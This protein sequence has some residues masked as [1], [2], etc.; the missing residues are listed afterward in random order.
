M[1]LLRWSDKYSVNVPEMDK[2]HQTLFNMLNELHDAMLSGKAKTVLDKTLS[3][4][5][6]YTQRHFAI[7]ERLMQENNYAEYEDHKAVHEQLKTRVRQ[8]VERYHAG[9]RSVTIELMSFLQD[10]LANHI[11]GMDKKYGAALAPGGVN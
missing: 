6:Q 5:I 3:Q 9:D 4:L 8:F 1:P 10:W 7:E 2:Q 11:V